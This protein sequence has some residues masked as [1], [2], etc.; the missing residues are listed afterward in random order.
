MRGMTIEQMHRH[1][2]LALCEANRTVRADIKAN[3]LTTERGT[4]LIRVGLRLHAA[5]GGVPKWLHRFA[6]AA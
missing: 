1:E 5:K 4:E 2:F 6:N 3:G